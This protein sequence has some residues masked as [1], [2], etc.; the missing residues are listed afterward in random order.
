MPLPDR[1][2]APHRRHED[3]M[4]AAPRV[5]ALCADDFGQSRGISA[6]IDGLVRA[7]RLGAVS[8]LSSSPR[9]REAAPLAQAWP[10]HVDVGLHFNLSQG[11]PMSGALR[12]RWPRFPSLPRL[13]VQA[14]LRLL[15]RAALA[16]ELRAQIDAFVAAIGRPPAFIDGHQH[17]H[18]LPAVRDL[19]LDAVSRIEPP[20]AVRNTG[21]VLGPGFALKR[22]LIAHTGGAALRRELRRRHLRHSPALVGAYDFVDPAYRA[23]MQG[24]L[25]ALPAEGALLFCHPGQPDPQPDAIA[26]ARQ[27]EYAYLASADFARDLQD[28][29][30]TPGRVW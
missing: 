2:R 16:R 10:A 18:H 3:G 7:G 14:H 27:R 5:L 1:R 28:A 23:L 26:A 30:V 17:V 15:P 24:W 21:R 9:W 12:A 13:I 20:P 8:C 29:G 25:R 11:A 22:W 19:V 6:G 4:K